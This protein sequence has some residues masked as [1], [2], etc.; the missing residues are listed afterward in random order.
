MKCF[1]STILGLVLTLACFF[2]GD[3]VD[4]IEPMFLDASHLTGDEF[5]KAIVIAT[6]MNIFAMKLFDKS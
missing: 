3:F 4:A 6:L 1:G 5:F 2:I